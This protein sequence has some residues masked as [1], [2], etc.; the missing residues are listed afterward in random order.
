M[1]SAPA[2]ARDQ[3]F[4]SFLTYGWNTMRSFFCVLFTCVTQSQLENFRKIS[5]NSCEFPVHK[6]FRHF[7]FKKKTRKTNTFSALGD[8]RCADVTQALAD[9][10][11]RFIRR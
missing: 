7:H 4:Q 5:A 2:I 6:N 9:H 8:V 1:L 10:I 11:I 3:R